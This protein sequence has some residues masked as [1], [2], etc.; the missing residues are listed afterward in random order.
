[1]EYLDVKNSLE[2]QRKMSNI[3]SQIENILDHS[4]NSLN[5]D[6]Q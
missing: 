4:R 2:I 6:G 3:N 1:M 5:F